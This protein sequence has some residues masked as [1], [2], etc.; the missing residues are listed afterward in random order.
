MR[1]RLHKVLIGYCYRPDLEFTDRS[2][3]LTLSLTKVANV[4]V[5]Q[6]LQTAEKQIVPRGRTNK[7]VSF[8]WKHCRIW[9]TD[10][11]V[12]TLSF[13]MGMKELAR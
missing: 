6:K 3:K 12:R 11:K 10:L 2:R 7:E 9:S 1:G 5:R 13:T 8:E 4:T